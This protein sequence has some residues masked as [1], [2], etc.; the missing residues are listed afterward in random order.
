MRPV[1]QSP[2]QSGDHLQ[3]FQRQI[4]YKQPQKQYTV[5]RNDD[6]LDTTFDR[7][8]CILHIPKQTR[9]P[10]MGSKP[11]TVHITHRNALD[12]FEDDR[13]I[14][15]GPDELQVVPRTVS[16]RIHL[17]KPLLAQLHLPCSVFVAPESRFPDFCRI[18]REYGTFAVTRLEA[19]PL[20]EHWIRRAVLNTNPVRKGEISSFEIVRTPTE[21]HSVERN[22]EGRKAA[23]F[24]SFQQRDDNF[25]GTGPRKV[26]DPQ[27]STLAKEWVYQ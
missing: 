9:H 15:V 8:L 12:A 26:S 4:T 13:P 3:A 7:F 5:V 1:S 10:S 19:E 16:A 24:R 23:R 22:H 6:S 17:A 20:H 14:P 2:H 27:M 18:E 21:V 11:F 25:C